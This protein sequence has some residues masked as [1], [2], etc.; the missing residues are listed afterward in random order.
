M[1]TE[2]TNLKVSISARKKLNA[3]CGYLDCTQSAAIILMS[4]EQLKKIEDGKG[5]DKK[6]S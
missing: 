4:K 6:P 5:K 2:W 1:K 3:V